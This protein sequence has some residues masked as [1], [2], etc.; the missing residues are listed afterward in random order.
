MKITVYL[1]L[2]DVIECENVQD[3]RRFWRMV[4]KWCK[5]QSHYFMNDI[6]PERVVKVVKSHEN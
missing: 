1:S 2:G 6:A 4:S 5:R 3:S